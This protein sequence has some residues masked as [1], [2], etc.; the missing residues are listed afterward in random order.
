VCRPRPGAAAMNAWCVPEKWDGLCCKHR[1][2]AAVLARAD[3]RRHDAGVVLYWI[4]VERNADQVAARVAGLRNEIEYH[5]YRYYVASD[6]VISDEEYDR[7]LREL[8]EL[9]KEYPELASP[10][11]PTQ[12]V[13]A[14]PQ[15]K[16]KKVPHRQPMLSLAMHSTR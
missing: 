6:P 2:P 5:N 4:F 10:D 15:E 11:S 3:A 1:P 9:E 14:E 8:R 12:R 16:F 7:L 13:G